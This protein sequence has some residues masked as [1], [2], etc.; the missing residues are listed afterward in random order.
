[1]TALLVELAQAKDG[2][3]LRY[4]DAGGIVRAEA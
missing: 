2:R 1:M 4:F 3:R